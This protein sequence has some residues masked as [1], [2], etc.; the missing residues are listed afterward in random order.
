GWL[1]LASTFEPLKVLDRPAG[2]V[3]TEPGAGTPIAGYRLQ[4]RRVRSLA[5]ADLVPW[6][7]ADDGTVLGWRSGRIAATT[8]HALFEDDGFRAAVLRWAA[9]LSGK[10]WDT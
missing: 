5:G 9:G 10:R 2:R 7:T 4:H 8:L 6:M 1:P 3:I